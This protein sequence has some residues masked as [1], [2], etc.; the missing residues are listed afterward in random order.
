MSLTFHCFHRGYLGTRLVMVRKFK[1]D[2]IDRFKQELLALNLLKGHKHIA[3]DCL[4]VSLKTIGESLTK[5]CIKSLFFQMDLSVEDQYFIVF[6][7]YETSL[8]DLKFKTLEKE[9]KINFT[10]QLLEMLI[11]LE[12]Y[13]IGY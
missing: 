6:D 9:D 11:L 5:F 12:E 7:L 10:K 13:G 8:D 1:K 2:H 4:N 3:P